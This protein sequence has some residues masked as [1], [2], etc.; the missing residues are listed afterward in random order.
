MLSRMSRITLTILPIAALSL[1]CSQK[2]PAPFE[3]EKHTMRDDRDAPFNPP[4]RYPGWAFDQP[5][6]VKPAAAPQPEPAARPNDPPHFFT[7]KRIVM[8]EQALELLFAPV[9]LRL[10]AAGQ[11][12]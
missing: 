9:S 12:P 10:G 3:P 4:E 6:Y 8:V 11:G 7:N 5:E 1:A 2:M